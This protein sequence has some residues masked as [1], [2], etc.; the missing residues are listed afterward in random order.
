MFILLSKKIIIF[1]LFFALYSIGGD[2]SYAAKPLTIGH[3][4]SLNFGTVVKPTSGS[5]KIVVRRNGTLGGGTTAFMLD[6]A[7]LSEG[8]DTIK[9][10]S[11][12]N[13]IQISFENCVSNASLGLELKRFRGRYAG[14]NFIDIGT[15]LDAPT[16]SGAEVQYGANLIVNS[17]AA[18]GFQEPCYDLIVVYE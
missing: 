17:T 11:G 18:T 3:T 2:H 14:V 10:A 13:T 6:T 7:S 16:T 8:R 15:G 12:N 4:Q 9:G 5:T 1:S